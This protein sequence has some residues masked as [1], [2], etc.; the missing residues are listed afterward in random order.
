MSVSIAN[1]VLKR[2]MVT[3]KNRLITLKEDPLICGNLVVQYEKPRRC[4]GSIGKY[5]CYNCA[6]ATVSPSR[7]SCKECGD[8]AEYEDSFCGGYCKYKYY[9][10]C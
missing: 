2:F 8:D 10:D 1:A 9:K 7:F 5:G 6:L 4:Y 3:L